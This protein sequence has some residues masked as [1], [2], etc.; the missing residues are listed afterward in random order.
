MLTDKQKNLMIL[1]INS[2]RPLSAEELAEE[3]GSSDRT[4]KRYISYLNYA[5]EPDAA[6]TLKRG[7][8]YQIS[9]DL[10]KVRLAL[11]SDV[12]EQSNAFRIRQIV[13]LLADGRCESAER[14]SDKLLVSVSTMTRLIPELKTLL[15][16]YDLKLNTRGGYSISGSELNMRSLLNEIGFL[17]HHSI[18]SRTY[19][20]NIG[21]EEFDQISDACC[22]ALR[23]KNIVVADRDM[24]SLI[25]HITVALSRARS[26]CEDL[27]IAVNDDVRNHNYDVIFDIMNRLSRRFQIA[28]SPQ[29]YNYV[30]IYSGLTIYHFETGGAAVDD[31]VLAFTRNCLQEISLQ[32]RIDYLSNDKKTVALALHLKIMLNRLHSGNASDN[33][34]LVMIKQDYPVEMDYGILMAKRV[35]EKYGVRVTEDEIGYLAVHLAGYRPRE[36]KRHRIVI[37]CHYGLG[38]SRLLKEKLCEENENIDVVGIYPVHYVELAA[39][40]DVDYVVSTVLIPDYRGTAPLI[41]LNNIFSQDSK[42]L[43]QREFEKHSDRDSEF[44]SYFDPACF[45]K[46]QAENRDDALKQI[47][48]N[49]TNRIHVLSDTLK[50]IK[51]REK[52]SSTDL[53][54]LCATPH[55]IMSGTF[56]STISA[57]ILD[58]PILWHKE[59]AQLIFLICFNYKDA[60]NA[61]VFRSLS[62]VIRSRETIDHLIQC[63]TYDQFIN[64]LIRGLG[65]GR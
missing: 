57:V 19:L 44:L 40:Q 33:P 38:T 42:Q 26:G 11:N 43:L 58:R 14:L 18:I 27:H 60:Q 23:Q 49:L 16:Q 10:N 2:S 64:C 25:R 8:G 3:I 56:R 29:E 61:E 21:E 51:E 17:Y 28:L 34:L 48:D 5:F 15:E 62:R 59:E 9:G 22:D 1:L 65:N 32:S 39:A 7:Y 52:I 20:I 50:L 6:I 46:I 41:V 35:E 53:G 30:S 47:T 13:L 63:N 36:K 55:T 37:V 4:I 12:D 45:M 54:N 24:S 31:E